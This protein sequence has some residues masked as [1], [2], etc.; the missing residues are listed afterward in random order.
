MTYDL[1][2]RRSNTTNHHTSVASSLDTI[3]L[4]LSLGAPPS[5]LNLG[6]AYYAKYFT[7]ADPS[8]CPIALN[9]PLL[10]AEDPTTGK[11]LLNSGAWTFEKAHM[12]PADAAS[13]AF[14]WDG[15]CG[16]DKGT[17]CVTGCCSQYGNCGTSLEHCRGACWHAFGTGCADVDVAASW[18]D[19]LQHGVVDEEA[20]GQYHLDR[21]RGLFWTWDTEELISSKFEKIV[22]KYKL[23]GVMAWSLGEDSADW[24][25]VRRMARELQRSN[26]VHGESESESESKYEHP[27]TLSIHDEA[28]SSPQTVDKNSQ[29]V[30]TTTPHTPSCQLRRVHRRRLSAM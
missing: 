11:D 24:G 5:K 21:E 25:R 10:P 3:E 12:Q 6:F 8:S 23:G 14:S 17:R 9:C 29:A 4:Y 19:A 13:L 28:M 30:G 27:A 2:N 16:P 15:T 22:R 20:G 26:E 18:Q 1:I 7:V